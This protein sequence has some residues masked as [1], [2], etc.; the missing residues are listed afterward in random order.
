M[1]SFPCLRSAVPKVDHLHFINNE[2]ELG[3]VINNLT[4][5]WLG[6]NRKK[7]ENIFKSIR[8]NKTEALPINM[9]EYVIQSNV[10]DSMEPRI[11]KKP[12]LAVIHV[13]H[14]CN[15]DCT[16]CYA[17]KNTGA[18]TIDAIERVTDFLAEINNPI[19]VQ[20]MGGEPLIYRKQIAQIIEK[21]QKKRKANTT[22][23]GIQTNGL[24]LLDKGV[25]EFLDKYE[26]R[27]GI[28]YDGPGKMSEARFEHRL[29]YCQNK[30]DD[31]VNELKSR[32]YS[33]GILAVLNQSNHL[34]ITKLV[35]W[36]L[37]KKIN[38]LLVNPLLLG[39]GK[40]QQHSL[41]DEQASKSMQS[42]F[43]YW[44]DNTLYKE[45]DIENFQ[46]F[47]DNIIDSH[48][49]YMCRKQYCG[50]GREQ[51]AFDTD[52]NI[53]PCDY[54][55]GEKKFCLGNV[56]RQTFIDIQ[57][58]E[59]LTALHEQVKPEKLRECSSCPMYSYCGNC[60]ASSYF[61]DGTLN[62]RRGSCHT[63]FS[64]I[65]D[66]IFELLSNEDYCSHVLSR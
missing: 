1:K 49:P 58:S 56:K 66:I 26:I 65:R 59:R 11:G 3:A 50:A 33:F 63:D 32:G 43:R 12:Q 23:Y 16:Y 14:V 64:S 44:V 28:S 54:L 60:M 24:Y 20:F 2:D 21:L 10:C 15:I 48:R 6:G 27:F 30:I 4:G 38:H 61:N 57:N 35:D 46:A 53:F 17:P 37:E 45:I 31:V 7:I 19:F 36:C 62:G 22:T 25:L 34:Q 55:V 42:L 29:D 39:Q 52:G 18:M 47:E 9:Q 13:G 41:T 51:L 5:A 40:S 8:L